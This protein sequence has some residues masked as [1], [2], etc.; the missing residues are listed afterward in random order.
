MN[1]KA[2]GG[3]EVGLTIRLGGKESL[4]VS[5]STQASSHGP[6]LLP[7]GPSEECF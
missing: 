5:S 4:Q 6:G 2:P 7:W 3:S 1:S